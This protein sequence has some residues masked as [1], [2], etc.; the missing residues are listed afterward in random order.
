MNWRVVTAIEAIR[1]A[2]L[3][4]VDREE[5]RWGNSERIVWFTD[6]T[7]LKIEAENG[8]MW[9]DGYIDPVDLTI[10]LGEL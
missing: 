7:A 8:G 10:S 3:R 6:G 9:G 4:T 1:F 2:Q 5:D